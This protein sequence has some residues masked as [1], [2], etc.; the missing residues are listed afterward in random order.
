MT[1]VVLLQCSIMLGIFLSSRA[2]FWDRKI[3]EVWKFFSVIKKLSSEATYYLATFAIYSAQKFPC[4]NNIR[5]LMSRRKVKTMLEGQSEFAS[6]LN[7]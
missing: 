4:M 1:A 2:F 3:D 5:N 7:H 6:F